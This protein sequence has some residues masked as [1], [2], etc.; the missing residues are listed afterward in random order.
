M[1]SHPDVE[2][3]A[4]FAEDLLAPDEERSVATHIETC[5]DCATTL[6][7]LSGVTRVLAEAPAPALPQDVVDLLDGR[8]AE[9]VNERSAAA[10]SAAAP[11]PETPAPETPA[12][13][14][15]APEQDG[16]G[17]AGPGTPADDA[18]APVDADLLPPLLPPVSEAA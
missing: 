3:L 5:A 9:A 7:E 1:T 4:F 11:A 12:P 15:P 8:I 16:S 2:A 18:L 13:E 10:A 6:D 17:N 14:T